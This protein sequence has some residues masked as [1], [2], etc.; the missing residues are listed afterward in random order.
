MQQP[1]GSVGSPRCSSPSGAIPP[2]GGEI[3]SCTLTWLPVRRASIP[4]LVRHRNLRDALTVSALTLLSRVLDQAA[5]FVFRP[6]RNPGRSAGGVQV[7][8]RL[9]PIA[10]PGEVYLGGVQVSIVIAQFNRPVEPG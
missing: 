10:L 3:T 9:L 8:K 5:G 2:P 7:F 6:L 4:C 1:A